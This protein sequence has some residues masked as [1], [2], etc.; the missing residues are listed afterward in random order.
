[1]LARARC[2]I[3]WLSATVIVTASPGTTR[4]LV[5]ERISIDGIPIELVR[6]QPASARAHVNCWKRREQLGIRRSDEALADA[7]LV[8]IVLDATQPVSR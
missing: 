4:D 8:L 2:S 7:A 3:V 5:T 6:I 1:M